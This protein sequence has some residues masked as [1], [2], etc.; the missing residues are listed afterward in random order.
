MTNSHFLNKHDSTSEWSFS[1]L[2]RNFQF[3]YSAPHPPS[4][5]FAP[6]LLICH[7]LL[8]RNKQKS[9]CGYSPNL[10]HKTVMLLCGVV[11]VRT[12]W[13]H[14]SS[15][16]A[17]RTFLK[18]RENISGGW[19]SLST[20]SDS[21]KPESTIRRLVA[22]REKCKPFS[23]VVELVGQYKRVDLS[24]ERRAWCGTKMKAVGGFNRTLNPTSSSTEDKK[25]R[26]IL[27]KLFYFRHLNTVWFCF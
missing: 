6:L 25:T 18:Y 21:R 17:A 1:A 15:F 12:H 8:S 26:L 9:L 2:R 22:D 13:T 14:H 10:E 24:A 7:D 11:G 16:I 20:E 3:H 23:L 19:C 5:Y 27:R 4:F